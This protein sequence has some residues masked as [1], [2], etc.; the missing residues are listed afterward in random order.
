MVIK[1]D[2][3]VKV[4]YLMQFMGTAG[5]VRINITNLF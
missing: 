5:Y 2:E 1:R 4:D 3:L